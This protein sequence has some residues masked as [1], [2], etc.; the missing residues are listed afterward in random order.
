MLPISTPNINALA[1][2]R[3]D[4]RDFVSIFAKSRIDGSIVA[5]HWWSD[6]G[7]VTAP[8]VDPTTGASQNR[9]F[10][11]AYSLVSIDAIPRAHNISVQSIGITLSQVSPSVNR[12]FREYN[13]KLARVEIFRGLYSP[14]TRE[15]VAPAFARF[16]G[17]VNEVEVTYPEEN[18]DG[19]VKFSCVSD[20]A[21]LTRASTET[22]SHES[23][24][25]RWPGDHFYVDTTTIG[26]REFF[27]GRKSGKPNDNMTLKEAVKK[28]PIGTI[29]ALSR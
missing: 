7:N 4:A 23:Q 25:R 9:N 24:L 16:V 19:H 26:E 22:R 18:S 5:E 8:V 3:I 28:D 12:I 13:V 17:Y 14:G 6:V 2:R 10:V 29:R 21:E 15:F 11:G 20:T 27:W 1:A